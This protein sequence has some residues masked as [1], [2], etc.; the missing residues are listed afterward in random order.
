[1]ADRASLAAGVSEEPRRSDCELAA[2]GRTSEYG[3]VVRIPLDL[4]RRIFTPTPRDS[5]SWKTAYSRRSSVERVNARLD[6]NLGFEHHTIR[7]LTKMRAR[8]GLALVVMLAM[9]L[10]FAKQG[11]LHMVRSLVGSPRRKKPAA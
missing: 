10:A 4:D 3:R 2:L 7:G 11:Q 1:M 6:Q 5:S 9:A 8:V